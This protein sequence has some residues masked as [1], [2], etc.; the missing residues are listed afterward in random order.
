MAKCRLPMDALCLD[1][2]WSHQYRDFIKDLEMKHDYE[3][4]SSTSKISFDFC[5][6]VKEHKQLECT[7]EWEV[8]AV[9]RAKELSILDAS[10]KADLMSNLKGNFPELYLTLHNNENTL[11]KI[12]I[13]A[14]SIKVKQNFCPK[15]SVYLQGIFPN[16]MVQKLIWQTY[17][18]GMTHLTKTLQ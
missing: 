15:E 18:H 7:I 5:D 6:P 12:D 11:Y 4:Q 10:A 13:I 17:E 3:T 8:S 2:F 1:R 14:N 16:Y 9:E